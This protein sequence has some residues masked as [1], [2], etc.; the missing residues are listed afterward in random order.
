M[1]PKRKNDKFLFLAR[2]GFTLDNP[3]EL[4]KAIRQLLQENEAFADRENEYGTFYRVEGDL[5]GPDGILN[6]VTIWILQ[7]INGNYRFVTLK[8]S[9]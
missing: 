9:R 7:D 8:P 1:T 2:V 5:Q 4:E 3:G 6:V